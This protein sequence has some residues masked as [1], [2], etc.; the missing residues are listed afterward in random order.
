MLKIRELRK[1]KGLTQV[2]LAKKLDITQACLSEI[3]T[4][5]T[6]PSLKLLKKWAKEL[7]VRISELI[8]ED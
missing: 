1:S 5:V 4:G 2:E 6:D 7:G 3:E 8:D